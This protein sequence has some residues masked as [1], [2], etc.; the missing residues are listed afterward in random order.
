MKSKLRTLLVPK[1]IPK[2][3]QGRL[4]SILLAAVV[5]MG[6]ET[7]PQ[8]ALADDPAFLPY[9]FVQG[10]TRTPAQEWA[11][12]HKQSQVSI[13]WWYMTSIV[14]DAAGNNYLLYC[15]LNR[16]SGEAFSAILPPGTTPP[17]ATQSIQ[18]VQ[19]AF[20]DYKNN[21]KINASNT[22][23][24][25]TDS[26]IWNATAG[27]VS[28]NH[29]TVQSSWKYDGSNLKV[30]AKSSRLSFDFNVSNGSQ[31]VWNQDNL[32]I[33]GV[34]QEGP[35]QQLS[36]YYSIPKT[37]L[38]GTIKYT[39]AKGLVKNL[40]VTGQAW[41]D[42]QW[43]DFGGAAFEW[44]SYRFD[45]GAR[46]NLYSFD[47]HQMG[48]YLKTDGTVQFFD[49][50]VVKQNG[51]A[52]FKDT[53]FSW[54]WSYELPI[55][56]EGSQKFTVNPYSAKD[57]NDSAGVVFY[58]GAGDLINDTTGKKVGFSVNESGDIRRLENGPYQRNQ[59]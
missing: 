18:Q 12:H 59:H 19:L 17:N 6:L 46:L 53:F 26:T 28:Y 14:R 33:P 57:V 1:I 37:N 41:F 30:N 54:G 13:E 3:N 44:A 7:A 43:G 40:A 15:V 56:V 23:F 47:G 22:P 35:P 31:V 29:P 4:F 11:P 2:L 21:F 5:G 8:T 58:E 20:S 50:Y 16:L 52:R 24:V 38:T 34:I 55:V 25:A 39:D 32:N 36:F 27:T 49:G 45:N 51:Y 10:K 48:S 42:R 9:N